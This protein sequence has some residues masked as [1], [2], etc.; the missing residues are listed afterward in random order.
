MS[1]INELKDAGVS[2]PAE[3]LAK[4]QKPADIMKD[5]ETEIISNLEATGYEKLVSEPN[6]ELMLVL[7]YSCALL[8]VNPKVLDFFKSE[9]FIENNIIESLEA[10]E[11][12][13]LLLLVSRLTKT[14]QFKKP[15]K[16]KASEKNKAEVEVEKE[17]CPL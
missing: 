13:K 6:E 7:I 11:N 1:L 2:I 16:K 15:R 9:E 10:L 5:V 8:S 3:I 14:V 17:D 4:Y 12:E